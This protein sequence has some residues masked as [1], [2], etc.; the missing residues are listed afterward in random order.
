MIS[1]CT[2]CNILIILY[3][4]FYLL[5]IM[6][7]N[8]FSIINIVLIMCLIMI[9]KRLY[10]DLKK[11]KHFINMEKFLWKSLLKLIWNNNDIKYFNEKWYIYEYP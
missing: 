6:F 9:K 5:Q 8:Y 2:K 7:I 10:S 4:F 3:E 11:K 1:K